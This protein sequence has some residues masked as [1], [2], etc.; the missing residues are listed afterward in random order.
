L[1]DIDFSHLTT[2]QTDEIKNLLWEFRLT[3]DDIPGTCR[4][5]T[6]TH[7]IKLEEGF[8]LKY[9][10]A[11]RIPDKLKSQVDE[12]INELLKDGKIAPSNS[13][14]AHP[15]VLVFKPDKSIRMCVDY[16]SVNSG[17]IMDRYPM[18]RTDDIL[19]KMAP[20]TCITSLDCTSGYYQLKID[21][22]SIP[23]TSFITH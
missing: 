21:P 4:T 6:P 11:Y 15:I 22:E 19:R 1:D 9:Q 10:R 5:A 23:L 8:K 18:P 13:P 12:Q 2:T 16:R 17:T 7:T 14:Y 3:F 20:S